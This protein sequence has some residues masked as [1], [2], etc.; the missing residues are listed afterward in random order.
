MTSKVMRA[1]AAGF[2]GTVVMTAMMC[3]AAPMMGAGIFSA[4]AGGLMAAMGSLVG[5]LLYSA[6][7]GDVAGART[8]VPVRA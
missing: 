1:A 7:M 6:T 3:G 5:H 8:L 4:N 2:V